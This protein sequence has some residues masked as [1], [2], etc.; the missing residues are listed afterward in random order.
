MQTMYRKKSMRA[1]DKAK[2]TLPIP[3]EQRVKLEARLRAAGLR[4]TEPRVALARLLFTDGNRHVTAE[5]LHKQAKATGLSISL[6][7]IYNSLHQF[8]AA[9]FLRQIV[10]DANHSYF[11][12]NIHPHHHFFITDENRLIDIPADDITITNLP[13]IPDGLEM[14]RVDVIIRVNNAPSQAE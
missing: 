2:D 9:G 3:Q 10:V 8:M 4:V 7:T 12:T 6:A 1:E 5:A 14:G 11:D 13:D